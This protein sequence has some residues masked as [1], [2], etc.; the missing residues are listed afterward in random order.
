MRAGSV[1]RCEQARGGGFGDAP[2][3]SNVPASGKCAGWGRLATIPPVKVRA[4]GGVAHGLAGSVD[5]CEARGGDV[6]ASGK[7]AG[8]G[9]L[10]TMPPGK[11]RAGG[12]VTHGLGEAVGKH[13]RGKR[14]GPM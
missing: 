3:Y 8:W 10:A 4:G 1:D 5:R 11:V 12:G 6:P 9:R 14:G 7:C 13:E 2:S